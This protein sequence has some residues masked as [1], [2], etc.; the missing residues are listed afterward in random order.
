VEDPAAQAEID[1]IF[2][3]LLD[4]IGAVNVKPIEPYD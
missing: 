4:T 1:R 3:G 2:R